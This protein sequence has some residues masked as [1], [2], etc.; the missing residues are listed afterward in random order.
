MKYTYELP[1]LLPGPNGKRGLLRMHWAER[2]K[3]RAKIRN[4]I[5]TLHWRDNREY[6]FPRTPAHVHVIR[7]SSK[8][9]DP[10]NQGATGKILLDAMR[11]RGTEVYAWI[12][13]DSPE[14]LT[15]ST[16]WRKVAPKQKK[17]IVEVS[18]EDR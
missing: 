13:D 14:H 8:Q 11:A 2:A 9:M 1:F 16:E 6:P 10:D 15:Y 7:C 3:W 17:T 18:Y 4:Y 12:E 5:L